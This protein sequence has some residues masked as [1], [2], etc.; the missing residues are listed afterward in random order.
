MSE[1]DKKK[2]EMALL[3][4]LGITDWKN[5]SVNMHLVDKATEKL[6]E[7]FPEYNFKKG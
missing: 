5:I 4:L 1:E 2:C 7:I 6:L 3:L